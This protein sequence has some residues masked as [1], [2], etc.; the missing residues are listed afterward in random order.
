MF[1]RPME[2]IFE[3]IAKASR[4]SVY[5]GSG[6]ATFGSKATLT[7]ECDTDSEVSFFHPLFHKYLPNA[8]KT[9]L[10]S[11]LVPSSQVMENI[12]TA[13]PTHDFAFGRLQGLSRALGWTGPKSHLAKT[14]PLT[15]RP[16]SNQLWRR[17]TPSSRRSH[18]DSHRTPPSSSSPARRILWRCLGW[19]GSTLRLCRHTARSWKDPDV[20]QVWAEA[21][22][23][24]DP[25]SG[26]ADVRG[27][28]ISREPGRT[29]ATLS[30][31]PAVIPAGK[32]S[33]FRF[34][35][36]F[37]SSFAALDQRFLAKCNNGLPST[38]HRQEFPKVI[39]SE[40][41][42]KSTNIWIFDYILS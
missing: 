16:R 33:T 31:S 11:P 18:R 10:N 29:Q 42:R 30:C 6:A 19:V 2:Q 37:L 8:G 38:T 39:I 12:I 25:S 1:D 20:T 7:V 26:S 40:Y 17:S 5:V 32:Y 13:L 22:G 9:Y 15:R 28:W 4:T 24:A 21:G 34:P 27:L 14:P 41:F 35:V 3:T 36:I 23:Q